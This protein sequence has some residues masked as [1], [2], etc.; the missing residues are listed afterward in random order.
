MS[1]VTVAFL[2][3]VLLVI[4][5]SGAGLL[6]ER[7]VALRLPT[8]LVPA[9]GFAALLVVSQYTVL[10]SS[11]APVTPWV[12]AA[13]ALLGFALGRGAV[14]ERWSARRRGSWVV[15]LGAAA[16][17]VT[18]AL[19]L[20]A[21]GRVTFPGYLLDT[22]AG[23]HL[24]V[25]DWMLHHGASLPAPYPAYGAALH[26]YGGAGYPTGGQVLLAASGWLTGQN[27]LW[28][29]FP[30]QVFALAL[31]GLVLSYVAHRAGLPK[32]ASAF[33]GWI[34]PASALVASYAMMG[35]IKELTA[36]PLLML[37]GASLVSAR[38][39]LRLG[40]RGTVPFALAA[41]G[42]VAAI[43][44]AA[45]AW[46]GVFGVGALAFA[47]PVLLHSR[48]RPA[49]D[50][51]GISTGSIVTTGAGALVLLAVLSLPTLTRLGVS[52]S[53]AVSLSGSDPAA[54]NDAGNLLRPLKWVQAFGVWLG[55]SHRIDPK[56]PGE[57]TALIAVAILCFVLGVFWLVRRR[58]WAVLGL[59]ISAMI[60]WGA[61]VQRG[62]EWTDAKVLMLTSPVIVAIALIGAF[63]FLGSRRLRGASIVLAAILG[64]G[65]LASD[66]LLYHATNL[67]P[68][69]RYDELLSIGQRFSGEGPTL[70]TDFDEYDFYALRGLRIDSPSFALNM[71]GRFRLFGGPP[72]YAHSNDVDDF[73][74]S[75]VQRF[76][77]IVM[78][79]SPRWSRPPGNFR[80]A[81][82]GSYYDVWRRVAPAPLAHV[83][84]GGSFQPVA[85]MSC[86]A[87]HRLATQ[88]QRD[89]AD[90]RYAWRQR[91]VTTDLSTAA[92]SATVAIVPDIEGFP[93]ATFVAP[94]DVSM[95]LYVPRTATYGVWLGGNV[96]RALHVSLDGRQ[97]GAPSLQSGDDGNMI[98]AGS[99]HV[100]AGRHKI[101]L[102][103]GGGG[104][105][106]GNDAGTSI[107]GV[108]LATGT[109]ES[110]KIAA[111]RPAA[112]RSL[113]GRNIDWLEIA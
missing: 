82:R 32:W 80:L 81:W 87:I 37:L 28:L 58:R 21:A 92:H 76:S 98:Y 69:A 61:L 55:P 33:T 50:S 40:V 54:A 31:T 109:E 51:S 24:A 9:S 107:D 64:G 65:V 84:V 44:P 30:F 99:I 45:V 17:Y 27:L 47:L 20:I 72:A 106:P 7:V 43:G 70:V 97:V 10:S 46:I 35:S 29:F 94:G 42:A 14:R 75:S 2:Y 67:A 13:L 3:P 93:T 60:V 101:L 41:G 12:L 90:L 63:G 48:R 89:G 53:K 57:T 66:S 49:R 91:N 73:T 22:T 36:L 96:D 5:S 11:V 26:D 102:L 71:A 108:F 52:V 38:E 113:C 77:L 83:P 8:L 88:A 100:P 103:R 4:L 111:L 112:W 18:V 56:Y 104:P 78:R 25:G 1:F 39:H 23:L 110:D 6:V 86:G 15:P 95:E 85:T 74:A 105:G 16:C 19:P 34:A 62:T 59:L 68:T 79:R